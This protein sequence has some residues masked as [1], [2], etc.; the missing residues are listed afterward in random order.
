MK[1]IFKYYNKLEEYILV[2]SLIFTT[3]LLFTQVVL[4]YIFN[5]SFSSAEELARYIFIWQIWLGISIGEKEGKH[6]KLDFLSNLLEQKK[7]FK[8]KNILEIFASIILICFLLYLTFSGYQLVR[9]LINFHSLS[10]SMRIPMYLVYLALPISTAATS[11]RLLK[12]IYF[13]GMYLINKLSIR[14]N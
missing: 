5:S 1:E 8:L 4:R 11:I 13:K 9:K 14:G 7:L 3:I 6:L 2:S 12:K 10:A